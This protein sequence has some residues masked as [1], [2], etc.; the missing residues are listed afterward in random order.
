MN[1]KKILVLTIIFAMFT[2]T[3]FAGTS[4]ATTAPSAGSLSKADIQLID[5]ATKGNFKGL[6]STEIKQ[7]KKY[8]SAYVE[9]SINVKAKDIK[10]AKS[11][12]TEAPPISIAGASKTNAFPSI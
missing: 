12:D 4:N 2:T 11:K 9:S 10:K 1:N 8:L 5:K 3:I 6:T 7:L